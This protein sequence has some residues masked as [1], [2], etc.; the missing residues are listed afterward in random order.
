MTGHRA[1][2]LFNRYL[3]HDLCAHTS[4]SAQ[5]RLKTEIIVK[6]NKDQ[7]GRLFIERNSYMLQ[8]RST[9]E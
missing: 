3:L 9:D 6:F 2:I 4:Y 7:V 1:A 5:K 8:R